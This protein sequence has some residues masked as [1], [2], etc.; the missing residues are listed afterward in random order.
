MS[1]SPFLSNDK[2]CNGCTIYY[3]LESAVGIGTCPKGA[4]LSGEVLRNQ[5]TA[6]KMLALR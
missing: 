1:Q 2:T 4:R 3:G 5:G 6:V